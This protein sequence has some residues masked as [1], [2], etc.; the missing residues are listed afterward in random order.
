[1]PSVCLATARA[2]IVRKKKKNS[3]EDRKDDPGCVPQVQ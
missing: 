2:V 1:M 3:F